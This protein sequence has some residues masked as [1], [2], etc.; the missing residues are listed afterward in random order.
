[1]VTQIDKDHN[2]DNKSI[3]IERTAFKH[4]NDAH[5]NTVSHGRGFTDRYC[6]HLYMVPDLRKQSRMTS[7]KVTLS[8]ICTCAGPPAP[9]ILR[10]ATYR[11]V[12]L[13]KRS[14]K[15]LRPPDSPSAG[16]DR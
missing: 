15:H 8:A 7:S 11:P 10:T 3:R 1:M 16:N 5:M 13:L 4:N 9:P 14:Q 2:S 12:Q 6:L